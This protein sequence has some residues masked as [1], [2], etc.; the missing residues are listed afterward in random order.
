MADDHDL[1]EMALVENI[2]RE[3]LDSIE[4]AIS[5]QRL[6]EECQLTQENLS[7]RVGKKRSTITNYLMRL[8][9]S[10]RLLI[11]RSI[12]HSLKLRV[13]ARR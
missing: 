11:K 1:L 4:I 13:S 9:T 6:I 7:L 8:T 2:Q 10:L 5:Y 12:I 3:D